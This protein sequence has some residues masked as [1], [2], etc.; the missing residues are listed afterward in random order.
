MSTPTHAPNKSPGDPRLPESTTGPDGSAV[1]PPR[2][3]ELAKYDEF[4]DRVRKVCREST[5]AQSALRAGLGKPVTE[6]PA[7]M[8]A[9]LLRPGLIRE[10]PEEPGY[11]EKER[12]YYAVAAL[13][14]ARPRAER[15]ADDPHGGD[16]ATES[17]SA[18]SSPEAEVTAFHPRGTS[19]GESI[20]VAVG[21]RGSDDLKADTAES[22][23]HLLV[24]QDL[25]GVHRML[26]G[27]LRWLGS[28]GVA[29][30]YACLLRD[31]TRWRFGR[32][33]VT[34]RWM[35]DFYRSLRRQEGARKSPSD[36]ATP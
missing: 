26:P 18:G 22:R 30:D 1:P 14:A 6:V 33:A 2:E 31:L 8:H 12:A 24:R 27:V 7:R 9:A 34:T 10:K 28:T 25:D 35:Q 23:L 16:D 20:A 3:G 19:L 17:A 4:V 11:R 32:D 36:A 5:G 15:L 13:F 21:R 29:P